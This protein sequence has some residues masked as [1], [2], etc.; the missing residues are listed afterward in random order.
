MYINILEMTHLVCDTHQMKFLSKDVNSN[1]Y[2]HGF[3]I[4]LFRKGFTITGSFQY[5]APISICILGGKCLIIS[6][7]PFTCSHKFYIHI[8]I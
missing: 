6:I 7:K 8:Y 1:S 5:D 3:N 4:F 2:S